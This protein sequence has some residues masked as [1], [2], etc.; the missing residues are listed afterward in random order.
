[1]RF[2]SLEDLVI[3][4][5]VAGRPRDLEDIESVLLKN[6]RYDAAFIRE[7]LK[8]F[9]LALDSDLTERFKSIKKGLRI[10]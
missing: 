9:D 5:I 2:A 10:S 4:K 1:V 8:E 3:H 6:P 7:C